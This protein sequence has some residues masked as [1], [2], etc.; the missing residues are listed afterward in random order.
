MKSAALSGFQ[1]MAL[2]MLLQNSPCFCAVDKL[3]E[4]GYTAIPHR[5]KSAKKENAVL[6]M[7]IQIKSCIIQQLVNVLS[8]KA[9]TYTKEA[10][11]YRVQF[12]FSGADTVFV[13][14]KMISSD[15]VEQ[16]YLL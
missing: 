4:E 3:K 2:S 8:L 15:S 10:F 13:G 14:N 12:S 11:K 1:T 16:N 5:K 6:Q 9:C 7:K